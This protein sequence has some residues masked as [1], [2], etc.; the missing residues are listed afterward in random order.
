[1][2]KGSPTQS[3][4]SIPWQLEPVAVRD[5]GH[6]MLAPDL[7]IFSVLLMHSNHTIITKGGKN[8]CFKLHFFFYLPLD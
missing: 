3:L 5:N 6:C 1:M 4:A 7:N 8:H 2:N